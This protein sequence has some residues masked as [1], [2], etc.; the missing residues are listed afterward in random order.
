M[1]CSTHIVTLYRLPVS[2]YPFLMKF[3]VVQSN[4]FGPAQ[5][6]SHLLFALSPST[7]YCTRA[8]LRFLARMCCSACYVIIVHAKPPAGGGLGLTTPSLPPQP[9]LA[10]FL[11]GLA[12]A[13]DSQ[14]QAGSATKIVSQSLCS[15]QRR[16]I[17]AVITKRFIR[18]RKHAMCTYITDSISNTNEFTTVYNGWGPFSDHQN[19]RPTR[20]PPLYV[21][22][23]WKR[24]LPPTSTCYTSRRPTDADYP[25]V[26]YLMPYVLTHTRVQ[27]TLIA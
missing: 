17:D 22:T 20:V 6:M 3:A 25:A 27:P 1:F 4:L 11:P 13:F 16:Q 14:P 2:A 26:T 8:V 21:L 24:G 9:P 7:E 19:A 12:L 18:R 5:H 10:S 15:S 23:T